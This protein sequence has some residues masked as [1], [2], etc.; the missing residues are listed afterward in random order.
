MQVRDFVGQTGEWLK[1]TGPESD[2]VVSS[3]V[4][5]ARNVAGFPFVNRCSPADREAIESYLATSIR[6]LPR[7]L[8]YFRLDRLSELERLLLLER[9]LISRDHHETDGVRGV[10]LDSTESTSIMI[11]EED[12][13]RMQVLRSGFEMESLASVAQA[14]DDELSERVEYAYSEKFGFLTAC[15][16]NVGT[17][18]RVSV[19]THLPALELTNQLERV[20]QLVRR[21]HFHIRGFYGEGSHATGSFYQISNQITLGKSEQ[22]TVKSINALVPQIVD[23]ERKA[24]ET[25]V[26][27]GGPL[28]E[29]RIYRA[30]G[31]LKTARRIDTGEALTLLSHVRLG[32]NTGMIRGLTVPDLN[33][34]LLSVQPGHLQALRG[35]EIDDPVQRDIARA[36]FIR[37]KLSET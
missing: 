32:I 16:T 7:P 34:I 22:E 37:N 27:K 26:K 12:H 6:S 2:V 36:E 17:G 4:R 25:L 13:I 11:N 18:M 14:L 3:R 33:G 9:H 1:G 15:P 29:D 23:T 10:A 24:R 19:M 35:S 31:L 8:I 20:F 28:L 21:I 5:L 30:L